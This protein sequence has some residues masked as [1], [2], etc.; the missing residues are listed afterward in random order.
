LSE[1]RYKNPSIL[2]AVFELR[3]LSLQTWGISSF[4]QFAGIA[5]NRGYPI[6]KDVS[7]SFQFKLP[8]GGGTS[9][10]VNRVANRVQTWNEDGSQLWQA[11]PEMFAANRR[12][13]YLGWA[14]FKPHILEGFEI[15]RTIAQPEQAEVL[16]M[17]YVN[18]IEIGDRNNPRDLITFLPPDMKYADGIDTFLCRTEQSF[19]DGDRIA[20]SSVR[21]ISQP[22]LAIIL[23]IL[24][25]SDKPNLEENDLQGII[26]KAHSRVV[27][28]FEM[29]ITDALRERME[30]SC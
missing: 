6:L 14:R 7:E 27:S 11:S 24:Y 4:V 8:M 13:P 26:E 20:I 30:V 25:T 12:A 16:K 19:N 9:P 21:D 3:F 17:Q 23:D 5:K 1:R 10:E 18:R 29:S 28:A 2:E 15:Y 22:L